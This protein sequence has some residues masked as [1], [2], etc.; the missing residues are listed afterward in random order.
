MKHPISPSVRRR[1][2]ARELRRLREAEGLKLSVAAKEASVPQSTLSNIESADARRIRQRDID[3][4]A[5]LYGASTEEREALQELAKE[6]KE[7]VG[8]PTTETSSGATPSP[9]S[10]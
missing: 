9:T 7:Q 10:R 8:G 3:A 1:R 6:S 5:E 2:L 4:L